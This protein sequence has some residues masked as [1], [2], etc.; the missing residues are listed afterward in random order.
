MPGPLSLPAPSLGP[1]HANPS[2]TCLSH[3]TWEIP[4]RE[5]I[6]HPPF[7]P[8]GFWGE[9]ALES[10]PQPGR[11]GF[12]ALVGGGLGGVFLYQALS[13][14]SEF[15]NP[16][17]YGLAYLGQLPDPKDQ[18]EDHQDDQEFWH[19]QMRH[20]SHLRSK[21]GRD[22]KFELSLHTRYV[23]NEDTLGGLCPGRQTHS[24]Q[25]LNPTVCSISCQ[26]N[27]GKNVISALTVTSPVA[28][29]VVWNV[30]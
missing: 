8:S 26:K 3:L 21:R 10:L 2:S 11:L 18:D 28:S 9:G 13:T 27:S 22:R 6:Y 12:G 1:Q 7:R 16:L 23:G 29:I 4:A 25:L 14:L 30:A 15:P 24:V 5:P 20:D 19:A 17:A